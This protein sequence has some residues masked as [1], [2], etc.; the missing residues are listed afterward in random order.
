MSQSRD[1]IMFFSV[2]S[3]CADHRRQRKTLRVTS[4]LITESRR[5]E[6][7]HLPSTERLL[8]E[9][10]MVAK[11]LSAGKIGVRLNRWSTPQKQSG[12]WRYKGEEGTSETHTH[13]LLAFTGW[14]FSLLWPFHCMS[15]IFWSSSHKLR[16]VKSWRWVRTLLYMDHTSV[17]ANALLGKQSRSGLQSG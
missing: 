5:T 15:Q 2:F 14:F 13:C 17:T 4:V 10:P 8:L 9:T 3:T 6:K 1:N 16:K 11:G 12:Q 7:D